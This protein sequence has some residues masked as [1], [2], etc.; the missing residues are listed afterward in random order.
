MPPSNRSARALPRSQEAAFVLYVEGARDRDLLGIWCQ[1]HQPESL[2][3]LRS[4]VILGGRQPNR[5]VEHFRE[6]RAAQPEARGLCILDRDH[7]SVREPTID[8]PGL[9]VFT[10]S[11][12]HIESYLLVPGALRR[13]ARSQKERFRLERFV[14]ESLPPEGDEPAWRS[15]DAK[16]LLERDGALA[17]ALGRPLP[18]GAIARTIRL[19]ELHADVVELLDRMRRTA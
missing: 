7:A 9:E 17:R 16:R 6:L 19:D 2:Q 11:R 5:A 8:E 10:W 14:R 12:R 1:R 3:A 18:A 4:A 13:L 15:L